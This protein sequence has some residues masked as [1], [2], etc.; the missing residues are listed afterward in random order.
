MKCSIG[1]FVPARLAEW[2]Q[3]LSEHDV[4][5]APINGIDSVVKDPQAKHL[6]L[7]VPVTSFREGGRYAVRPPLQFNGERATL[8]SAAPLLDEH[9]TEIRTVLSKDKRWPAHSGAQSARRAAG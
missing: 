3:R 7:V 9:G 4:P 1:C 6:G 5:F 8:V 2:A